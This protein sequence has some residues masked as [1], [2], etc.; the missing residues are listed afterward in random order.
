MLKKFPPKYPDVVADHITVAM[1]GINATP[2]AAPASVQFI[3]LADDGNGL[4]AIIC[5]VDGSLKRPDGK[6]FHITW[7]LDKSKLAPAD[8]DLMA[9][10]GRAK[11]KPYKPVHANGLVCALIDTDGNLK[12]NTHS[13]WSVKMFAQ[14]IEIQ[15][16]PKVQLNVDELKKLQQLTH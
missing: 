16:K 15:T 3:G 1:G 12:P 9:K 11:E 6:I 14:P 5:K 8:L 10:P 13:N 4:Q 2:P 7:S